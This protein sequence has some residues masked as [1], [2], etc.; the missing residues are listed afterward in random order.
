MMIMIAA[1]AIVGAFLGGISVGM[2]LLKKLNR[3]RAMKRRK[4]ADAE[5]LDPDDL[6]N[7]DYSDRIIT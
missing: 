7:K 1:G 3:K 5:L 4:E 2:L 6:I